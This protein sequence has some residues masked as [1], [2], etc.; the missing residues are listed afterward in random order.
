MPNL[1]GSDGGV[2]AA[3]SELTP[4]DDDVALAAGITEYRPFISTLGR[5][6]RAGA[7]SSSS[8]G[9][10]GAAADEAAAVPELAPADLGISQGPF[11]NIGSLLLGLSHLPQ[12]LTQ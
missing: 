4:T 5:S 6:T 10:A 9:T 1:M 7:L 12:R 11:L 2:G 8:R 3:V